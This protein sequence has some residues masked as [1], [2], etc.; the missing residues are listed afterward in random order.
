MS[1]KNLKK[2]K[3][4]ITKT[5]RGRLTKKI[6]FSITV[7][8]DTPLFSAQTTINRVL[9]RQLPQPRSLRSLPS[10]LPSLPSLPFPTSSFSSIKPQQQQPPSFNKLATITIN[11]KKYEEIADAIDSGAIEVYPWDPS[12]GNYNNNITYSPAADGVYERMLDDLFMKTRPP[13]SQVSAS[14][15][16]RSVIIHEATHAICDMLNASGTGGIKRQTAESIGWIAQAIALKLDVEEYVD[17]LRLTPA[18]RDKAVSDALSGVNSI[19]RQALKVVEQHNLCRPSSFPPACIFEA[20]IFLLNAT[21][22]TD[23]LYSDAIREQPWIRFDG[24]RDPI[25]QKR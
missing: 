6:N 7:S 3:K 20:Q 9:A 21:I 16:H 1:N 22:A 2:L 23:P 5:L 18:D 8:T 12:A 14:I 4:Y 19:V 13:K 15:D 24:I 17:G 11:R 10:P 25:K